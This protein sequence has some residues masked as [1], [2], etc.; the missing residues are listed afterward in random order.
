MNSKIVTLQELN[1]ITGVSVN[2][3][4]TWLQGWRFDKFWYK[5]NVIIFNEEFID[6]FSDF[7]ITMRNRDISDKLKGFYKKNARI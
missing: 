2:T 6:I 1:T 7:M 4:R 3:L 5:R